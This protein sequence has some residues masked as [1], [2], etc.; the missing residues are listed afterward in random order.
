MWKKING[1][2]NYLKQHKSVEF[3][4]FR[5][6][7]SSSVGSIFLL[8]LIGCVMWVGGAFCI[9]YCGIC[10]FL[11]AALIVFIWWDAPI[12]WFWW[13]IH[14]TCIANEFV[15]GLCSSLRDCQFFVCDCICSEVGD[16]VC[17]WESSDIWV[18]IVIP[19]YVRY[20]YFSDSIWVI[21]GC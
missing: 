21:F 17:V 7:F 13:W 2:R 18:G 6:R 1:D 5:L 11:S 19:I 20:Y 8:L 9:W 14:R 16:D 15:L 12:L 3:L 10:R 4:L